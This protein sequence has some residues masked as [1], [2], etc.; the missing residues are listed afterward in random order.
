MARCV[1]LVA[2]RAGSPAKRTQPVR[3][4][5]Q[6]RAFLTSTG[7]IAI[8]DL[9]WIP[10]FLFVCFLIHPWLGM[11]SLAGGVLLLAMTL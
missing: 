6:I 3:D 5:D 9:P 7:P 11:A 8:V 2:C 1:R 10:V 4:L